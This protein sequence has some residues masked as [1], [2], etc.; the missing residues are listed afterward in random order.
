L[1]TQH[2][3]LESERYKLME[4]YYANAI[5]VT[6]LRREQERIGAELRSVESRQGVLDGSFEEWQD[7]MNLALRFSTR[8][9]TAYHRA[10]DR[11]R[12]LLNAAVLDEV[13]VRDGHVV[14]A[15]YK[16]KEP[17]D[18][19]FSSPKF[20]YGDVVGRGGFEPP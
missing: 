1:A 4:A 5:D 18:L 11:T 2:Q 8:C 9:A 3:R 6:M 7:V 20:E 19:L 10:G 15:A 14:E 17:F 16:D 13:H 12:R